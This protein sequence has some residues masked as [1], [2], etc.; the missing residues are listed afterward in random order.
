MHICGKW[1][2]EI[3]AGTV[4]WAELPSIK[5]SVR[6]VQINGKSAS[7]LFL[8]FR[9]YLGCNTYSNTCVP[10]PV[11]LRAPGSV[12]LFDESGEA[13]AVRYGT[14]AIFLIAT[15]SAT[16]AASAPMTLGKRSVQSWRFARDHSGSI[17]KAALAKIAATLWINARSSAWWEISEGDYVSSGFDDM[18]RDAEHRV[19]LLTSSKRSAR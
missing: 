6:R 8:P 14:G 18:L 5:D 17:W 2:R 1:A 4:D 15:T 7:Y 9:M 19:R 10:S 16:L 13:K 11:F 12:P 3:F